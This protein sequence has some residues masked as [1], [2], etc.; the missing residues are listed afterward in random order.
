MSDILIIE[1][2]R[3]IAEGLRRNLEVEGFS[4]DLAHGGADGLARIREQP[5]ELIVL[6]LMLPDDDGFRVL[7]RLR[8]EGFE[9]PVLI[10]SARASETEKVRGFRIGAD[11]YVTKPFGLK[12][13]LARIDALFRRRRRINEAPTPRAAP[14]AE[15]FGDI[16]IDFGRREV[17]KRGELIPLRPKEFDLLEAMIQRADR[18]VSRRELLE[19]VWGYDADVQTRT[20]D[21]H[22]VELRRKLEADPAN[23][24][25]IVTV[26]KAGYMLRMENET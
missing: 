6:D 18:I 26:R 10:L 16:S 2:N 7:R 5:P 14:A 11:D 25:Y 1:D 4:V 20:V 3:D 15:V 17:R 12:E 9:M 19:R 13:L 22:M 8:D 24:R 21:T 23:P